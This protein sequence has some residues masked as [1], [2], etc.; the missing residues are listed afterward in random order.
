MK[1]KGKDPAGR[2]VSL[3]VALL[4]AVKYYNMFMGGVDKSD[5]LIGYYRITRQTQKYWKTIFL[6]LLEIAATNVF[7]LYKLLRIGSQRLPTER[8]FCDPLVIQII[9]Q[10]GLSLPTAV[11]PDL[12]MAD[13]EVAQTSVHDEEREEPTYYNY[14]NIA[15]IYIVV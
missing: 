4:T 8:H 1:R 13:L 14:T 7:I 2:H 10:Y 12:C 15:I 9:K 6:H 5:Q 3:D 11:Y